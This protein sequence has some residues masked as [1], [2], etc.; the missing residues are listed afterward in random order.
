MEID[1][2]KIKAETEASLKTSK[3]ILLSIFIVCLIFLFILISNAP[4]V[5]DSDKET[6]LTFPR[7]VKQ[8]Q[9]LSNAI[10][11]YTA[12]SYW[13]V[14]TL[15]CFL[16][17]LLQSF[18][19][20]GPLILSILA[21]ALFG[22]LEGLIYVS[23]CAT[24]GASLCYTLSCFFGKG[25]I[26]RSYPNKVL[27]ANKKIKE[28]SGSISFLIDLLIYQVQLLEFLLYISSLQLL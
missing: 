24:S 20:P 14:V 9:L 28:H 15:F 6:F 25:I 17:L 16:Y 11:T 1:I 12:S 23:L 7:N 19:I 22:R 26:V 18:A 10:Q 5:S 4:E 3:R 21:G 8:I 27:E 2:E 13:Y